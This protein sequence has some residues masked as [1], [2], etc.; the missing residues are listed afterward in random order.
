MNGLVVCLTK[1]NEEGRVKEKKGGK[2]V[3]RKDEDS[4]QKILISYVFR[5]NKAFSNGQ[6]QICLLGKKLV[7]GSNCMHAQLVSHVW[8]FTTQWDCSPP[9]FSVHGIFHARILE[10]VV[11][12]S[13]RISSQPRGWNLIAYISCT[14]SRFFTTE[15]PANRNTYIV[16]G[17]S[18]EPWVGLNL[19]SKHLA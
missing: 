18:L 16:L 5:A 9:G 12:S 10:W 15:L 19:L 2:E 1:K 4:L 11:I 14:C 17:E 13:S 6:A 7:L 3:R 8:L